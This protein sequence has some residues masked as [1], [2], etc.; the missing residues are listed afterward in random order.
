M[1]RI[2]GAVAAGAGQLCADIA[3]V[4]VDG[5]IGHLDV[6]LI[7]RVH[8]LL[9]VEDDARAGQQCFENFELD[10]SQRQAFAVEAEDLVRF[11][12]ICPR[13]SQEVLYQDLFP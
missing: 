5:A 7:G 2:D 3:D 9:A 6:R 12:L 1:H 8:D 13:M 11:L 10:R 4:T